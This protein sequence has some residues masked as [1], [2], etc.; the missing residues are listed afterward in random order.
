MPLWIFVVV[1]VVCLAACS[2]RG[3]YSVQHSEPD[4]GECI[5]VESMETTTTGAAAAAAAMLL[6]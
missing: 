3:K 1:V 2:I 4:G 6:L 5:F